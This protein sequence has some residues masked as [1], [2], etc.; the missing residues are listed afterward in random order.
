M[1]EA[2]DFSFSSGFRLLA[3]NEERRLTLADYFLGAYFLHPELLLWPESCAAEVALH[4]ALVAEPSLAVSTARLAALADPDARENYETVLRFLEALT[5]KDTIENCYICMFQSGEIG[6]PP[7]FIDQLTHVIL[8]NILN[9]CDDP[10]R[11]RAAAVLFRDQRV[12]QGEGA[13]LLAD[14]ETVRAYAE[15]GS[16]AGLGRLLK[17]SGTPMGRSNSTS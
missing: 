11:L 3:R 14:D 5:E 10:M 16:G 15:S 7:L 12:T 9:G 8:R 17:E 2:R 13:I 6:S 4:D 1:A